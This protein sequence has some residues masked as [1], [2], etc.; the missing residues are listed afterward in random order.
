[1]DNDFDPSPQPTKQSK[2]DIAL[3]LPTVATYNFRSF[4]PK[5]G[6]FRTDMMERSIDV[7]FCCELWEKSEDKQHSLE[8]E[9]LLELDGL[10]YLSVARTSKCGGGAALI[11]NLKKYS[12]ERLNIPVPNNLEIVWGLLKPKN[13]QSKMRRIIVCSFYSPP[14]SRKNSR[15]ADHMVGTLQMLMTKYPESGIICGGDKNSMDITPL[16][17]CGLRLRQVVDKPTRAGAI[18]DVLIMN[19]SRFFNSPIIAPPICPDDPTKGKPSDHSVPVCT[20]HTDRY[21]PPLRTWRLHTYRP[22]PDSAVRNF[23]QWMVSQNW[24]EISCDMSA[25]EQA[26]IFEKLLNENLNKFCP[27]RTTKI[28]SQDKAFINTELKK[29][30]RRRQREYVKRGKSAK[31]KLLHEEFETK[32]KIEAL[33]YMQKNV[34]SLKH[35]NPGR[36]Y[37]VLKRLGAQPGDCTDSNTFSLPSHQSD[38]LT[39]AESAELIA[40]HFSD[41]S[42]SFPPLAVNLLPDRAQ[43]KLNTDLSQPPEITSEQ[44]WEKI[45]STNKPKSGVP[46]DLPR[47][48]IKE[49]SIELAGP[50]CKIIRSIVKTAVWPTHWKKEY[51]TPIGKVPEPET[52]DDLRPIS[53]TAFFSKVTEQFVVM[54]LLQYISHLIDFRQY[55]GIKGNSIT[56]YLVEFI[57]FIL[58][59][60][61]NKNST[62]ILACMIDFSKAFNRQNHNIL[63]TKLSDMGVPAWLL[64]IIMSFLE[65]RIMVVRYKGATSSQKSLPGGGPQGTLLGLLLFI[66]L[67]NDVG[68]KNQTNNIGDLITSSK[69]LK[70]ANEIHLKFVDDLTIAESIPLKDN[71]V[72]VPITE[73][74]LPDAYHARTGHALIAENSK[75]FNQIAEVKDY[76]QAND[77]KLNLQKTKFM[78]FN[79]C[80]TLDFMPTLSLEGDDIEVVEEMKLLG[81]I[82][83]SDMKFTKNTEYIIKKGFRRIWMLRRLKNLG[84]SCENLV[85]VYIKQIRSV[86]ELAVPVWHSSLTVADRVGIERVQRAALQV[87]LGTDYQSYGPALETCNLTTLEERRGKLCSKFAVKS[88][89]HPKHMKWFKKNTRVTKTRQ[90]QPKFCSVISRTTRF[91]KSPISFFTRL[92]NSK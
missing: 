63:I 62:A 34:D 44:T 92:L 81:V 75:V 33:K 58:S 28:G 91:E 46:A 80:R 26:S 57:T 13:G 18:L 19:V 66:V 39:A 64:R 3:D 76:A 77:M 16:L 56:H 8:I 78:L 17:S 22:L 9:K 11:V 90:K 50:L 85:E 67:I 43:T 31:Y 25:T 88:L 32:Y 38:N 27:E 68:F 20:P 40:D 29:L 84:A 42:K 36:A 54:W 69:N 5:L 71:L 70:K 23:G 30:H 12:I 2:F 65:E 24:D 89:K 41:I 1:M 21:N 4:F 48:L 60:Q 83:T 14:K 6:H 82:I 7:A 35:L 10:K 37:S 47:Q 53:L 49:F 51:V 79:Q 74:P 45:K 15:L 52:E 87:I 59:N 61:E 73:R 72:E 55:G 86:L